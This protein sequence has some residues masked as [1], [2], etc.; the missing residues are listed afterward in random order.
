[1][2]ILLTKRRK[3]VEENYKCLYHSYGQFTS[4]VDKLAK[5]CDQLSQ[6]LYD[7]RKKALHS[8]KTLQ[9]YI[10]TTSSYPEAINLGINRAISMS[11]IIDQAEQEEYK[12]S[13]Q[14][15]WKQNIDSSK[16]I[17]IGATAGVVA[18][19]T[20]VATI[21]PT[22]AMAF[23][24]TFGSAS[25][26]AA[27]STLGGAAATNA[28]LA[29][30]GGGAIAAGGAGI[31]GGSLF[32]SLLGPIGWGISGIAI[33][34]GIGISRSK[35][36][37][38]IEELESETEQLQIALKNIEGLL[39]NLKPKKSQL[40][41]LVDKTNQVL[42]DFTSCMPESSQILDET[43]MFELVEKAKLLGKMSQ[44]IIYI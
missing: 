15:Q 18:T 10:Y 5:S 3:R 4:Q 35:N 9:S 23:A 39:D 6:S 16:G 33:I 19:G 36:K 21:G 22:A 25:T 2:D 1:M 28:A 44:E 12:I 27:I 43:K 7:E 17:S 26:G 8:I 34:T 29:W 11:E 32:L 41:K 40:K 24:T 31:A 14:K 42:N 38:A 37:K 13:S 20:T 30:L